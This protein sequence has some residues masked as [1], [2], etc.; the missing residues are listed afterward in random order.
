MMDDGYSR[1][2]L[3]YLAVVVLL[4]LNHT[5]HSITPLH[6]PFPTS[7]KISLKEREGDRGAIEVIYRVSRVLSQPLPHR[8]LCV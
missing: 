2:L 6:L 3:A 4:S 8:Y 5:S 7:T 1:Y